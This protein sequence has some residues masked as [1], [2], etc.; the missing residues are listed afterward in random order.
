M[1]ADLVDDPDIDA[2]YIAVRLSVCPRIDEYPAHLHIQLPNGLH[3]EWAIRALHANKHVLVEK[4]M[5]NT[6]A[7]ARQL[8][9]L[10]HKKGLVALEALHSTFVS[11]HSRCM[12]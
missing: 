8:F 12:T 2:V 7:E 10:A 9:A 11:T 5:T 4:P 3:F 1:S 6:A